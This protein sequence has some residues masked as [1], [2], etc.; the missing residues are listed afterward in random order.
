MN[1]LRHK[2]VSIHLLEQTPERAE[3]S[4]EGREKIKEVIDT[5]KQTHKLHLLV[6]RRAEVTNPLVKFLRELG[7]P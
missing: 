6:C 4:A 5:I 1:A 2:S 3:L 7:V